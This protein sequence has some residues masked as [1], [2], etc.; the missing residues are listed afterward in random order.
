M[1]IDEEQAMAHLQEQ[2]HWL[3]EDT[4][5]FLETLLGADNKFYKGLTSNAI[6]IVTKVSK[7]VFEGQRSQKSIKGHY[8]CLQWVLS[9]IFNF[10]TITGNG[11]GDPDIKVLDKKI[12]NDQ[13]AGKDVGN[14]SGATLK[15]WYGEGWYKLFDDSGLPSAC[16]GDQGSFGGAT[17]PV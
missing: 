3:D 13:K 2:S 6:H 7:H 4:K 11:G 17:L 5:L 9:Y 8:E 16:F 14:L 10:E 15:K 12:E 1:K